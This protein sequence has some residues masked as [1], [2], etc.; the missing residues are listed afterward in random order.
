MREVKDPI[1]EDLITTTPCHTVF[2]GLYEVS[3][4]W[5]KKGFL[6]EMKLLG[7]SEGYYIEIYYSPKNKLKKTKKTNILKKL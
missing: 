6:V 5:N 7:D 4:Y 1:V 3:S 2:L